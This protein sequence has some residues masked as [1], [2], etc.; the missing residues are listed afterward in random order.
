MP[1]GFV[2]ASSEERD[3]VP[4]FGFFVSSFGSEGRVSFSPVEG[5]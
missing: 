1:V 5:G 2:K 4:L 3:G